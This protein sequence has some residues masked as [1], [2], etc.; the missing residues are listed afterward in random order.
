M[1]ADAHVT[2]MMNIPSPNGNSYSIATQGD[3]FCVLSKN[4]LPLICPT[5]V[6]QLPK[7]EVAS[8]LESVL[9]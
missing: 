4:G 2:D 9:L 1:L 3:Q 5:C 8:P 6:C 7:V